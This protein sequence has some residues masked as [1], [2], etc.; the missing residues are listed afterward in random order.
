MYESQDTVNRPNARLYSHKKAQFAIGDIVWFF[1]KRKVANKPLKLHEK[2][3]NNPL[4]LPT[5]LHPWGKLK[6]NVKNSLMTFLVRHR[7]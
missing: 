2:I 4:I 5:G 3:Q 1:V 6:E 7:K